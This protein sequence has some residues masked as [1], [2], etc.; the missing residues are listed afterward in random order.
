MLC[1][2]E[3]LIFKIVFR[4]FG[5][6]SFN[7]THLTL[8]PIVSTNN[9]GAANP[10]KFKRRCTSPILI[11]GTPGT[12]WMLGVRSGLRQLLPG[13]KSNYTVGE[14]RVYTEGESAVVEE[15]KYGS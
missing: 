13:S 4:V 6:P 14:S 2:M 12:L 7:W 3:S 5:D 15:D 1:V 8:K 11:E 10:A 9:T